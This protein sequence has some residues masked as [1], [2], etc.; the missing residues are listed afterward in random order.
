VASTAKS[1]SE[2]M[3]VWAY[4]KGDFSIRMDVRTGPLEQIL[5][6]AEI[7]S[8]PLRTYFGGQRVR[9]R[10]GPSENSGD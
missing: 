2:K 7:S 3:K 4:D 10:G 9:L 8:D 5:L 6:E 1:F